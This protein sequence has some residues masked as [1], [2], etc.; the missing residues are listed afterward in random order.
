MIVRS[1]MLMASMS[2]T[3]GCAYF[4]DKDEIP[5]TTAFSVQ[6]VKQDMAPLNTAEPYTPTPAITDYFDYYNLSPTNA[7]HYFGTVESEGY[8]L[9]AHAFVPDKP[10]GTLILLHGYFDHTATLVNLIHEGISKG[11]CVAVWD[12]PGHGLS[13]GERTDTDGFDLCAQQLLDLISR[14]SPAAPQPMYLIGHST[15]CS[16]AMEYMMNSTNHEIDGYVFLAPLVRHAHWGWAKFGYGLSKPFT[17]KVRRR[18]KKNSSDEAYLAFVKKDPLHHGELSFEYLEELYAWEHRVQDDPVWPGEVL[19]IQGD[20][21]DIVDWKYNLEFLESKI[22]HTDIHIIPGARHQL[23]NEIPSL[24]QPVFDL[25]F[26]YLE[27]METS[28]TD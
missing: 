13:T 15:G 17:S 12:L 16:I 11:Y 14:L 22:T 28:P 24:R 4:R 1:I 6:Q 2:L 26:Q 9:A 27:E 18:D 3:T 8:I 25:I 10:K 23:A 21:D 5:E 20:K 7:D 19:I